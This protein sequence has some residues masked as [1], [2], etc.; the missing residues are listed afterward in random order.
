[1]QL[2][3]QVWLVKRVLPPATASSVVSSRFL[4]VIF[5]SSSFSDFDF[6]ILVPS[7][8][9]D[10]LTQ[11]QVCRSYSLALVLSWHTSHVTQV[12]QVSMAHVFD[13]PPPILSNVG[14]SRFRRVIFLI[15]SLLSFFTFSSS[16]PETRVAGAIDKAWRLAKAACLK[17]RTHRL[18]G[19]GASTG[20]RIQRR[21]I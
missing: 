8:W 20:K 16:A 18:N 15:P 17:R 10:E 19:V 3:M 4:S 13:S 2:V 1:M 6:F 9:L 11:G 21:F 14:S 7:N 12:A 5:L